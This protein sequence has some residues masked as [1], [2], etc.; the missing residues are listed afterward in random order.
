MSQKQTA[1]WQPFEMAPKDGT[2][3]IFWIS[4]QKGFQD[5]TA[6]FYFADEQWW[7][8]NTEEVLKRPDL[9]NGWM[10]YPQPPTL[11]RKE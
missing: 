7:W 1:E 11:A 2:E 5:T 6:N 8:A 9:V 4:S 10:M 3:L